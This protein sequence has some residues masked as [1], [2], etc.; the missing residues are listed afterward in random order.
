MRLQTPSMIT[1]N[2]VMP[3]TPGKTGASIGTLWAQGSITIRAEL[4]L[5][6]LRITSPTPKATAST[7]RGQHTNAGGQEP[8]HESRA[9]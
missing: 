5:P 9:S 3:E 8:E 7:H 4:A 2:V 6:G 1:G